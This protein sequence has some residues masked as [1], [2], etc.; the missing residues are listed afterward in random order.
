M[1]FGCICVRVIHAQVFIKGLNLKFI[2][3]SKIVYMAMWCNAIFNCSS[4]PSFSLSCTQIYFI[5]LPVYRNYETGGNRSSICFSLFLLFVL[6]IHYRIKL[7]KFSYL[8]KLVCK[9]IASVFIKKWA[10][11]FI[12]MHISLNIFHFHFSPTCIR[13]KLKLTIT[14]YRRRFIAVYLLPINS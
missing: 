2:R 7:V 10:P 8:Q 5:I 6:W 9:F 13:D 11:H 1:F 4:F 12:I 14:L 3:L